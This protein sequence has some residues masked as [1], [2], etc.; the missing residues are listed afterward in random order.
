MEIKKQKKNQTKRIKRKKLTQTHKP[1][2]QTNQIIQK[3]Q[4]EKIIFKIHSFLI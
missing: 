3:A 1:K 2:L 4:R